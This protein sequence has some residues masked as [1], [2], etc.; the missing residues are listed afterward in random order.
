MLITNVLVLG[1][2]N[3]GPLFGGSFFGGF[4]VNQHLLFLILRLVYIFSPFYVHNAC[5]NYEIERQRHNKQINYAQDSPFLQ[6]K[7]MSCPRRW[8]LNPRHSAV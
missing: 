4:T 1:E 8:D 2:P 6:G 7:I 5:E 3:R